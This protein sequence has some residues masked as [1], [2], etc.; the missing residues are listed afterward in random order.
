MSPVYRILDRA[1]ITDCARALDVRTRAGA[2][3]TGVAAGLVDCTEAVSRIVVRRRRGIA[4]VREEEEQYSASPLRAATARTRAIKR[5][6]G[7]K[8]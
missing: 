7:A 3:S 1:A 8:P 6:E 5:A 4:R 2:E